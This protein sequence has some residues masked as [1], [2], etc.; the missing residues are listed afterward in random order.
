MLDRAI[1]AAGKRLVPG[2]MRPQVRYAYSRFRFWLTDDIDRAKLYFYRA[3]TGKKFLTWY[4]ERL[5][6]QDRELS[7]SSF[8][9]LDNAYFP[10]GEIDFKV[11]TSFGIKPHH[12]VHEFGVGYLRT[13]SW[14]IDYLDDGKFS[15]NDISGARIERGLDHYGRERLLAKKPNLMVTRDMSFD[16]LNGETV[17]YIWCNAVIAHM[18]PED[19]T[20]LFKNVRKIMHPQ[21]ILLATY[22]SHEVDRFRGG[23][24]RDGLLSDILDFANAHAGEEGAK[25]T[26]KD[27][28]YTINFFKVLGEK[29]GFTVDDESRRLPDVDTIPF[30]RW[31]ML[32][33]VT[34]R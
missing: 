18:P 20:E 13:A 17:D 12:R 26:V 4:A 5:E 1:R 2:S 15:G 8:E 16:W 29:F 23:R 6:R 3:R 22:S 24:E 11:V 21:T 14:L 9:F 34:L 28:F 10:S 32:L 33:K 19:V 27:F 25:F 30:Q 7:A 31:D